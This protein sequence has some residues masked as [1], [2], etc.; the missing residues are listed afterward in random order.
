M[1][2]EVASGSAVHQPLALEEVVSEHGDPML[3][4]E[5]AALHQVHGINGSDALKVEGGNFS[6]SHVSA[7]IEYNG[8]GNLSEF[9]GST[10]I[11]HNGFGN[12][13]EFQRSISYDRV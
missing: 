8:F 11:E 7:M 1:E 2:Q 9:Q 13:G 12:P 6:E 3:L 4:K 5:D 10:M